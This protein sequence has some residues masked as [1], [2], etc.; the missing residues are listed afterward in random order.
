MARMIA[1]TYAKLYLHKKA[2]NTKL[3]SEET[4]RNLDLMPFY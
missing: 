1:V 3:N 4:E 2:D